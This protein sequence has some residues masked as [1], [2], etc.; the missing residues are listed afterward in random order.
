MIPSVLLLSS[1]VAS[2]SCTATSSLN[3][4]YFTQR[5]KGATPIAIGTQRKFECS[6]CVLCSNLCAFAWRLL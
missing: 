1:S 6:L 2:H 3:N 5:R 4:F